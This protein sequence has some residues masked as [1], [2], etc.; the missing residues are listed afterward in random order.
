MRLCVSI[1]WFVVSIMQ[2]LLVFIGCDCVVRKI[3][4]C[5][6][7][8]SMCQSFGLVVKWVGVVG[9]FWSWT[10]CT[11]HICR[12]GWS[13]SETIQ[14]HTNILSHT[15][16]GIL[17]QTLVVD[18]NSPAN[19]L[20]NTYCNYG[21]WHTLFPLAQFYNTRGQRCVHFYYMHCN[22]WLVLYYMVYGQ[23]LHVWW[24]C[25]CPQAGTNCS[26]ISLWRS[27]SSNCYP[28]CKDYATQGP[29]C[30]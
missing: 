29:Y 17:I 13:T 11:M 27:S 23:S 2:H 7:F 19:L 25:R 20:Y 22:F 21:T 30:L 26:C 5:W 8:I 18:F 16:R 14:L 28:F 6:W 9:L 4:T 12:I 10:F 15:S 3:D 1:L 24:F